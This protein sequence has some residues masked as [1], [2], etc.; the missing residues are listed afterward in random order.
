[1]NEKK[2]L[3][4]ALA[5]SMI[6]CSGL[7]LAL[8]G[9]RFWY[10]TPLY[11]AV[12]IVLAVVYIPLSF[13]NATIKMKIQSEERTPT[14]IEKKQMKKLEKRL[15]LILILFIPVII[16]LL[17]DY[18]YISFLSKYPLMKGISALLNYK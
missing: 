9:V 5:F 2:K 4:F 8:V 10:V 3:V 6:V 16:T 7:Y 18:V 15:K 1:M 13:Q 12:S 14:D 17:C 11:M